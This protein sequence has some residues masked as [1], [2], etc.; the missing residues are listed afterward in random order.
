MAGFSVI[1]S[2]GGIA[3]QIDKWSCR[4]LERD[5]IRKWNVVRSVAA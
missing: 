3:G 2:K 5:P 4:N 1:S